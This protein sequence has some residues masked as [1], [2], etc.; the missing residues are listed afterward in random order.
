MEVLV[1]LCTIPGELVFDPTAGSSSFLHA[2]VLKKRR[3]VGIELNK[4]NYERSLLRLTD[5]MKMWSEK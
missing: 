1:S 5:A 4:K 2:A 3:C